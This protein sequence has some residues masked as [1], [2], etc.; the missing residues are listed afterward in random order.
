MKAFR[1]L[2]EF[3][4]VLSVG[5]KLICIYH[6][7]L[8]GKSLQDGVIQDYQ[9]PPR[10]VSK[11]QTNMFALKTENGDLKT[12][13]PDG[14]FCDS[15]CEYPAASKCKVENNR[16][17]IMGRDAKGFK[18]LQDESNPEFRNLPL[19]PALTYWFAE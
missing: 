16:L 19:I 3:K 7:R 8:I 14:T 4:R 15:W 1:T 11:K 12:G 9:C 13:I 5:D 10:E 6:N 17:I 18:G 2:A